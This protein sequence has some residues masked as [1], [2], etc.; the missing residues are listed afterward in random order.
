M[1]V[2]PRR[3]LVVSQ[4]AKTPSPGRDRWVDQREPQIFAPGWLTGA[5]LVSSACLLGPERRHVSV[6]L[7]RQ[8]T[9]VRA[10][11]SFAPSMVRRGEYGRYGRDAKQANSSH[12]HTRP[13]TAAPP[14]VWPLP[15]GWLLLPVCETGARELACLR[16]D[17]SAC[18]WS[19]HG[20]VSGPGYN[21]TC[22]LL[23][24]LFASLFSPLPKVL[25][26]VRGASLTIGGG[27][28]NERLPP[29]CSTVEWRRQMDR[30]GS[31]NR[32]LRETR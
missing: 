6:S 27:G 12:Q 13:R 19:E 18:F 21:R 3:K 28:G 20:F 4:G 11:T 29:L 1:Q 2:V 5:V 17:S 32:G 10:H 23:A 16:P 9:R 24:L 7:V 30:R 22:L 26:H 31:V 14:S 15:G 8:K 25:A